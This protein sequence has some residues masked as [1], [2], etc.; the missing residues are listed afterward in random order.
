MD[1]AYQPELWR[2]LYV[3]LGTSAAAL[4]GLL[5][6]VTSLH[7]DEIMNHPVFRTRAYNITL[8]LLATLIEAALILTPQPMAVLGAELLAINLI[9]V[10]L[11]LRFVY[12][13]FYRDRKAGRSGSYS[14]YRAAANISAYLLGVAAGICLIAQ[15]TWGMYLITA[16]FILFIASA[17]FNA[18]T[19]MQGVGQS[20]KAKRAK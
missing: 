13:Y 3:M 6:V 4:I 12:K 18:W 8:H 20:G 7:L 10:Q 16:S 5:F 11:P 9:G 2:D 1:H 17:I 19:I 14:V 15:S